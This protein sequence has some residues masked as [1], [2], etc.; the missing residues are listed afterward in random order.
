MRELVA[1][2]GE[3]FKPEEAK[4]SVFDRGFLYGDGVYEVARSYGRI[5]FGLEEHIDRLFNSAQQI[6]LDIGSS[7]SELIKEIYR[8]YKTADR[9]DCYMRIVV[10]RGEGPIG[11]DPAKA[12]KPN[13]V[14]FVKDIPQVDPK[15]YETG[16]DIITASVLRN[17][18]KS[19]DP[20]IKS[21]NYLNNVMAMG[22]ASRQKAHDAVMVNRD[23]KVTEGTTWNIFM[24]KNGGLVTAPDEADILQG[25]TRRK[26]KS[27]AELAG[28]KWEERYFTSDEL[29]KADEVF[30]TGSV[31]EV[32]PVKTIDGTLIGSG[33][34][35]PVTLKL[36]KLYKEH[37]KD[38]CKEALAK[39]IL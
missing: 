5:F 26:L 39:G 4:I 1:V 31:K 17:P 33:K 19:L 27:I 29:K 25:I 34:V 7:K 13:I 36:A 3:I 38:Y 23:G 37:V 35:G 18:K 28:I 9:D 2:N 12:S 22:E 20:N 6:G 30:T 14:I 16:M 24:V 11:L 32:M 15:L 10:T 8:I 21:G